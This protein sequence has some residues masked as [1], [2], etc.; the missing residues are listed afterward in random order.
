MRKCVISTV[1]DPPRPKKY[2]AVPT[3]PA[4]RPP[5]A[6]DSAV[7]CGTAVRGTRDSGTPTMNPTA[8]APTIQ[9]LWMISGWIHVASTAT[10]IPTT[11]ATTPRRAVLGS[12]IQYKAKM[13]SAVAR[14]AE[15]S[16]MR[17][18]TAS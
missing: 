12:F 8:M 1:A 7:R 4:A 3:R 16:P 6:C 14:T 15:S 11:P 13:N 18:I 5:N 9:P 2:S 10:V 17:C